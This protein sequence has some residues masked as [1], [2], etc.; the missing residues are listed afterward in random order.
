MLSATMHTS[1]LLF[2]VSA[3]I[4]DVDVWQ[5]MHWCYDALILLLTPRMQH[6]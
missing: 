5:R 6:G 2:M 3:Y 4:G 1:V